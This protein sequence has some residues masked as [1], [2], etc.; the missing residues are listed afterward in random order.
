MSFNQSEFNHFILTHHVIGFFDSPM[1]LKSGRQS[2][3][4]VNWRTVTNDAYLL[5]HLTD[6]ILDFSQHLNLIP[7]TFYGVP[8]GA[9]KLGVLAQHKWAKSSESYKTGSHTISMGRSAPKK[10]GDPKDR[11]FIGAPQGQTLIIEDV[12]TTGGSLITTI[13]SLHAHNISI[14]GAI[15]LTNRMEKR[16]DGLSVEDALSSLNVPYY[17]MSQATDILPKLL[18]SN[19]VSADI[20]VAVENEFKEFGVEALNL[21]T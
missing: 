3:W 21:A 10:H 14:L 16:D 2:N 17:A 4:Y 7:D 19:E 15:G 9:S 13:E 8:E 5:D 11:Y 12:T 1:T 6:F 20:Q 18:Q